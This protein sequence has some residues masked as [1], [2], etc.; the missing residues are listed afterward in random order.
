MQ[1]TFF[2][3]WMTILWSSILILLFYIARTKTPLLEVC[4]ISGII[5]LY[6][7]CLIRMLFPIEFFWTEVITAPQIYNKIYDF[8]SYKLN[9][10]IE[11]HIYEWLLVI[12]LMGRLSAWVLSGC[13]LICSYSFVVQSK[14]EVA[15]N[16]I[17][18]DRNTF[19]VN[20]ENSYILRKSD[21]SY[22]FYNYG[23]EISIDEE[24]AK[25]LIQNGFKVKEDGK[26][27]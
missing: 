14:Y 25:T 16:E 12:S 2:S 6:L 7:F 24:S 23:N 27:E 21:G 1:I 13:L 18:T 4:S 8:F 20:T 9:I 10:G 22:S 26:S 5:V 15:K 3:V 11:L 17:E 19:E